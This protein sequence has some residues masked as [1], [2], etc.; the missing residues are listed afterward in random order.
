MKNAEIIQ[1]W[2]SL[3]DIPVDKNECIEQ[4]FYVWKKGTDKFAIWHWFDEKLP[5]GIYDLVYKKA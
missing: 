4:D 5:N 1:L 3:E 2:K